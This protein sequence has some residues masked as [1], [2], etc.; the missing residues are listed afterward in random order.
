MSSVFKTLILPP[1]LA[2]PAGGALSH[3]GGVGHVV[4][5]VEK[6]PSAHQLAVVEAHRED[7]C[8]GDQKGA[9]CSALTLDPAAVHVSAMTGSDVKNQAT[10]VRWVSVC[11]LPVL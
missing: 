8:V 6:G 7:L 11:T 10:G 3:G 4:T 9:L 5:Q 1:D 2:R